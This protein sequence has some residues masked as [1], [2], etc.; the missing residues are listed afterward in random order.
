MPHFLWK[1]LTF[2]N[3]DTLGGR[4]VLGVWTVAAAVRVCRHCGVVSLS[5][6][7]FFEA[8]SVW[9]TKASQLVVTVTSSITSSRK[10]AAVR[11]S[12][13]T[14]AAQQL[15]CVGTPRTHL[16]PE[17]VQDLRISGLRASP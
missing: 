16:F 14:L 8:T 3:A 17:R 1:D 2:D 10:S 15:L 4:R 5:R 11:L 6:D 7:H 12:L 13:E 9:G